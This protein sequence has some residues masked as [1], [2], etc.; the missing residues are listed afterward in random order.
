MSLSQSVQGCLE[1]SIGALG[2][3]QASLDANLARLEPRLAALREAYAKSTLP[4]LARA[5]MAR[6]HRRRARRPAQAHPRRAHAGVFRHWRF[7]PW[8][9][10]AG[11][12]RRLGHSRRRRA[13]QREPSAHALLRQSRCPHA[14][15]QPRRA[16]PQDLA[17]RRHLEIRRHA[18]DAGAGH[19]PPSTPCA[20]LAWPSAS[21]SCSS[22]SPSPRRKERRT[23]CARCARPSPSPRSTTILILAA[24][25]PA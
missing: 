25:S 7:E 5:R 15:A 22:P 6:R 11:P 16:R 14:R 19:R 24:A 4:L 10:D 18:G 17:L 8:R 23:A 1:A 13:W 21:P 2:L 3:P 9:P 20:R 12:A